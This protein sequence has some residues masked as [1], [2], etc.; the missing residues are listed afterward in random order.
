MNHLSSVSFIL[1]PHRATGLCSGKTVLL[2]RAWLALDVEHSFYLFVLSLQKCFTLWFDCLEILQCD[3]PVSHS[4]C[5]FSS[6]WQ[7]ICKRN[8]QTSYPSYWTAQPRLKAS[9]TPPNCPATPLWNCASDSAASWLP[10]AGRQLKEDELWGDGVPHDRPNSRTSLYAC[11]PHQS[12]THLLL[13]VIPVT[14]LL[15]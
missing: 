1:S 10:S 12:R 7:L 3:S 15:L 6:C 4:L 13:A 11:L 9:M 14:L 5:M 2:P 8:W